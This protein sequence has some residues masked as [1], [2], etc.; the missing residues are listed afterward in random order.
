MKLDEKV[1]VKLPKA[2]GMRVVGIEPNFPLKNLIRSKG[3]NSVRFR[4]TDSDAVGQLMTIIKD[5]NYEP[6]YHVPPTVEM[7]DGT[8]GELITGFHRKSAHE[9]VDAETMYVAI[10][11]FFEEEGKSA[12]YWRIQWK[13]NENM[14]DKNFVKTDRTQ[15]DV[16]NTIVNMIR[17][18]VITSSED[19]IDEALRDCG[20]SGS[21]KI[22]QL[23]SAIF[24]KMGHVTKVVDTIELTELNRTADEYQCEY[25]V[26][27]IPATFTA[28]NNPDYDRRANFNRMEAIMAGH[29]DHVIIARVN[30]K[31]QDG[32]VKIREKKAEVLDEQ[33]K[34][35]FEFVDFCRD[36]NITPNKAKV[37]FMGQLYNESE[38][39]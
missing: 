38:V 31:G 4:G 39:V 15:E 23:R 7:V 3:K 1:K 11:E 22:A 21:G 19:D 14:E 10:V 30:G 13:L 2:K 25:D 17:D 34:F 28:V 36:R 12:N 29:E 27:T 16:V 35:I 9:G 8:K 33:M 20:E 6:E 26:K 37:V 32:V 5:G 18:K 24:G